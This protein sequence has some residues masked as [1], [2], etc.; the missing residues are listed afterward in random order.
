MAQVFK[1]FKE[2]VRCIVSNTGDGISEAA[3]ARAE[4]PIEGGLKKYM[5]KWHHLGVR[6]RAAVPEEEARKVMQAMLMNRP[7]KT[8][9]IKGTEKQKE[10]AVPSIARWLK[11]VRIDLNK[12]P[13]W[14]E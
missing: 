3:F 11:W 6:I 10:A 8:Y 5:I 13:K 2:L 14:R 7:G 4:E 12:K 9:K 1:R